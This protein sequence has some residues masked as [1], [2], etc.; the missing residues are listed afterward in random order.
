[1]T[2]EINGF[3]ETIILG[4]RLLDCLLRHGFRMPSGGFQAAAADYFS[5]F[6]SS[7]F[8]VCWKMHVGQV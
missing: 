4:N 8:E 7:R 6:F 1:M 5:S 2:F 3:R